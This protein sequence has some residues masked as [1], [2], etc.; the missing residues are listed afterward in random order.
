MLTLP[1]LVTLNAILAMALGIAFALYG[2]LML[3][4]FGIA[5]I[6]SQEALLY[7]NIASFARLFGAGIFSLGLL[8][9][10]LRAPLANQEL[11][12]QS[13]RGV[14]FSL[15]LGNLLTTIVILTQQASVWSAATGWILSAVFGLLTLAYGFLMVGQREVD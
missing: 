15:L 14:I 1:R 5:D 3:A 7:W 9:F 11:S 12:T 2:P 4:F 6:P 10:A 8:L 13:R